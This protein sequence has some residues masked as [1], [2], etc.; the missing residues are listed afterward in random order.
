MYKN[1]FTIG[2][3]LI[4]IVFILA[5]IHKIFAWEGPAAW[6]TMKGIPMVNFSLA[7][8][9][10]VELIGGTF[11]LLN[12]K[13]RI[14]ALVLFA[15]FL[16]MTLMMHTFWQETGM[17]F[18]TSLLDFMQNVAILGG[19]LALTTPKSTSLILTHQN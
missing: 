16:P 4:G 10:A 18:Q 14:A 8:A 13:T 2:R 12:F 9:T 17:Q 15:F 7:I 19:L 3:I 11:L 5:G 1:L 6:M